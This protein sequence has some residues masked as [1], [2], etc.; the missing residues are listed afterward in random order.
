[1]RAVSG[2]ARTRLLNARVHGGIGGRGSEWHAF[3]VDVPVE[4]SFSAVAGARGLPA[5]PKVSSFQLVRAREGALQLSSHNLNA[6]RGASAGLPAAIV[7]PGLTIVLDQV[8]VRLANCLVWVLSRESELTRVP[9][10]AGYRST[11]AR[12]GLTHT[13][14]E[15]V[16]LWPLNYAFREHL[17]CPHGAA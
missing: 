10:A 13:P 7:V 4:S 14:G 12:A 1:M 6:A 16:N 5:S 2:Q 11:H 3:A 17:G 9:A 15:S 8:C